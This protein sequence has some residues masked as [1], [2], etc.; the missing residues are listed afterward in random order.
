MRNKL[1]I[2]C[3]LV[4]LGFV[5]AVFFENARALPQEKEPGDPKAILEDLILTN[6]QTKHDSLLQAIPRDTAHISDS[7]RFEA[8]LAKKYAADN[9]LEYIQHNN[10]SFLQKLKEW[11]AELTRKLLGYGDKTDI[12]KLTETVLD[13]I[14]GII[15][16]IV[17]YIATRLVMKHKGRWF[18]EKQDENI[19]IDL[20]NVEQ[21]IREADFPTLFH[22][23]EQAGDSRQSVRLLYLWML[24]T[25]TDREVIDWNPDKTNGDY[26]RE[27]KDVQLRDDFRYLSYLYNYIWYGDFSI[28]SSDY[29]NAREKFRKQIRF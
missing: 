6:G 23:S 13:I 10:K 21:Y 7:R 9:E 28:S 12:N 3:L 15:F 18:F 17:A 22:E 16:L 14:Y 26:M 19:P 20:H 1:L 4:V 5:L 25:L 27:I 8:N 29:R 11:I 24:R 2:R